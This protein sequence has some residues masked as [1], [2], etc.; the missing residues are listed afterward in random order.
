MPCSTEN[1]GFQNYQALELQANHTTTKGL[2]FQANYTWEHDISDA[3]GDAPTGFTGETSY[4]IAVVDRYAVGLD[5]GNV[6]GAPRQ[7]F[8]LTGTLMNCRWERAAAGPAG[9]A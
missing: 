9:P 5:R 1:L 6:A 4:G 8:L 3:Q 2:S 7:R